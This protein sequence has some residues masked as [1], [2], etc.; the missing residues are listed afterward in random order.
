ML[1]SG[2]DGLTWIYFG[3]FLAIGLIVYFS[4]GMWHSNLAADNVLRGEFEVSFNTTATGLAADNSFD[5]I[6]KN[7]V[8]PNNINGESDEHSESEY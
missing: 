2:L 3:I 5:G 6:A 1:A 8:P 4:Y 7:Y